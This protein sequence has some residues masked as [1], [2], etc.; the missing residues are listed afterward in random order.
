MNKVL[1]HRTMRGRTVPV[2]EFSTR[3]THG[4]PASLA[5]LARIQKGTL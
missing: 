5:I 2:A 4:A 3:P 1:E